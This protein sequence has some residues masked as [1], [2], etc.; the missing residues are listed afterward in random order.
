MFFRSLPTDR[1]KSLSTYQLPITELLKL[2]GMAS[3]TWYLKLTE[4]EK[5][6]K[7]T[8]SHTNTDI[9]D[10][11]PECLIITFKSSCWKQR[12]VSIHLCK[13]D[14][15]H[16]RNNPLNLTS[17]SQGCREKQKHLTRE[18]LNLLFSRRLEL[19]YNLP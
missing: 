12:S 4:E 11:A 9:V 2:T 3:S 19:G 15:S 18:N 17:I 7:G 8:K 16:H 13:L 6:E 5:K 10:K 14:S 1:W